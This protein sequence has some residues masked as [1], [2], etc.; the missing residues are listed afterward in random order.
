MGI[1]LHI[2]RAAAYAVEAHHQE[3]QD[4]YRQL[5]GM[6]FHLKLRCSNTGR[7]FGWQFDYFEDQFYF[8]RS[9]PVADGGGQ[10]DFVS[11]VLSLPITRL[12]LNGA[13]CPYCR[14]K[15]FFK[16]A[17]CKS[18]ICTG[19]ST[20]QKHYWCHEGC[21]A[22]NNR[23]PVLDVDGSINPPEPYQAPLIYGPNG[24]RLLNGW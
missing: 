13:M 6:P 23:F 18:L 16:C 11:D 17:R 10:G 2:V 7:A 9:Y 22:C 20:G 14:D 19:R 3:V 8:R 5:L 21:N 24:R 12:T 1:G 15:G 4:R